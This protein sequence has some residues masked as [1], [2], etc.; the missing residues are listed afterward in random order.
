[1]GHL[2]AEDGGI[3]HH[4]VW[5]AKSSIIPSEKSNVPVALKDKKGNMITNS[6]GIKKLC[7]EEIFE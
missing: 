3:S 4:G 7:L 5:K 2:T 6:E 1:M